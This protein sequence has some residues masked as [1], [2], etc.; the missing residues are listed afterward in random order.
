MSHPDLV[1]KTTGIYQAFGRGD[2]QAILDMVADDVWWGYAIDYSLPGVPPTTGP[3]HGKQ[4][5]LAYFKNV[6]EM[7]NVKKL[8]P[9][10]FLTNDSAVAVLMEKDIEVKKTGKS[11]KGL[12]VHLFE[13]DGAG[14]IK[15]H[16]HFDDT[17]AILQAFR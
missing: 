16:V 14:K 3:F 9:L 7:L 6:G 5:V 11:Y 2:V 13:Y 12:L 4:G 17:A 8:A 1:A 15:R 10:A